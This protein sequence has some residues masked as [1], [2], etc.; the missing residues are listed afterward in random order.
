MRSTI[1]EK[2]VT[3]SFLF[4]SIQRAEMAVNL[5]KHNTVFLCLKILCSDAL[6]AVACTDQKRAADP[7]SWSYKLLVVEI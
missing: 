3:A 4:L 2:K 1:R 6:S 7:Q 5:Y